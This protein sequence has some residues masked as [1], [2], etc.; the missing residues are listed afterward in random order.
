MVNE[1][2]GTVTILLGNGD[3]TFTAATASP[4]AGST[5]VSVSVA[6]LNRDGKPDL[7]V[8]NGSGGT[9]TILLG[10]GD[11]TFGSASGPSAGSDP[12]SIAVGDLNGDG[13]QDLAVANTY[14]N[15]LSIL[16]LQLTQVAT[17]T[18]TGISPAGSGT[19]NVEASYPGDISYQSSVSGTTPLTAEL[20]T[21]T[22][23]VTPSSS[24]I[25]RTQALTV[26]VTVSGGSGNSVPTG[27]VTLTSGSYT[28]AA[29]ILNGGSATISIPA[30]SLAVGADTLTVS[31]TPDSFSASICN[32]T[33]GTN[34][35][36]VTNEV[37]VAP[38]I[39]VTPSSSSITTAQQL[40]VSVTVSGGSGNAPPSGSVTLTSGSYRS[41][42]NLATGTTTFNL[43][44]GALPVGKNTLSA[45][46]TPD[47]SA[48][49]AYASATQ[50]ASVTVM[51]A[52]GTI[53]PTIAAKSSIVTITDLESVQ[54]TVSLSGVSGHAT[55]TGSISLS[56][57]AYSAQLA[58]SGGVAT[59]TIT[60]GSLS[61]GANTLTATYS[62]DATYAAASATTVVTV[63]P[64]VMSVLPLSPVSPGSSATRSVT[65]MAG[66][67]YSGTI[68][69]TCSLIA[70]PSGA[71]GLP[72]C[73]L[74]PV[75]MNLASGGTGTAVLTVSTTTASPASARLNF[76][77]M[78]GG[79]ILVALIMFGIPS[80]RHR[81]A[82]ALMVL[83]VM[84][85]G[86][87][88]GC[89]GGGVGGGGGG[90]GGSQ[91][92]V[93]PSTPATTAGSYTFSVTATDAANSKLT[94]STNVILTVE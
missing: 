59:F 1:S 47:V 82:S 15:N 4:S 67:T 26:K 57:G 27:S 74:N 21:P 43:G 80:R 11:G 73:S 48:A 51:Q 36:T 44:A 88:I 86:G 17:A 84:A 19:H 14:G 22:L 3:G 20:V 40:T 2:S 93:Q 29:L 10:N 41:Q 71:Q 72:T 69:L 54:A 46:Y 81:W 91:K 66:S 90:G 23:T 92:S 5:P 79:S 25:A 61:S 76:W 53:A 12:V 63:A 31:Y 65:L 38:A 94:I 37:T 6:D 64:F 18:A 50:S 55:P 32:S 30:G 39:S 8:A 35:V 28:S 60:P 42:H 89:G 62:G 52:P 70:S 33:T 7:V 75:S 77:P 16:T 34:S 58:L 56:S 87:V 78:G 68:H 13:I 9:I 85:G 49:S 24:S 45:T 83:L